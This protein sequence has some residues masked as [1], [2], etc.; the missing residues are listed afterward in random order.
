L[1][2][3]KGAT[4]LWL[5]T[6]LL[7]D[8]F[9]HKVI[10]DV[11]TSDPVGLGAFWASYE[12]M[13]VKERHQTIAPVL[14][15]LRQFLL[16]PQLRAVLGQAEPKFN[17]VDI[18]NKRRILLIPLNRGVIGEVNAKLLGSLIV[19]QLFTLALGRAAVPPERRHIVNLFLDE[20][21]DF[22]HLPT[23]LSDALS[24]ARGLGLGLTLAHQ[25]RAQLPSELKAGI[26]ANCHSK[27]IFGLNAT[28]ARDIAAMAPELEVKDI[29]LQPRYGVYTTFQSNGKNVGWV[30]GQTLP[31]PPVL[32]DAYEFKAMSMA[33]YGRDIAEVEQEYMEILGL[34]NNNKAADLPDNDAPIGRKKRSES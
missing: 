34:A 2:H 15:K 32:R 12:A 30:S 26:D 22:L 27:I 29:I 21:Q 13:S 1:T 4:L 10:K 33:N 9:R 28:D 7:D 18:F 17:L 20:A 5:P 25:Y 23:D 3:I 16:R 24:Q 19:G 31:P 8:H 6:L 11:A 14:N